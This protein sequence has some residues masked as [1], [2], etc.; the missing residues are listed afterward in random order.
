MSC[1][2][3]FSKVNPILC[4]E[5][6]QE[7]LNSDGGVTG[8]SAPAKIS[9]TKLKTK[10]HLAEKKLEKRRKFQD[11]QQARCYLSPDCLVPTAIVQAT[12]A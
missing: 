2:Q 11:K 5:L 3:V 4:A 7:R 12:T 6:H 1:H 8:P 10:Q 9:K